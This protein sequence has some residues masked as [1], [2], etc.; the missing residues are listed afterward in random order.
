M[1]ALW[2]L[3]GWSMK[4]YF[5][6]VLLRRELASR[7]A[8]AYARSKGKPL[9][10]IGAGGPRALQG[11]H[12]IPGAV[13]IDI[14]GRRD[15]PHG[16]PGAVTYGDAYDLPFPDG[17]FG[18]VLASHIIEHLED[19]GRA[20]REWLRVVGGDQKALFVITPSWWATY[21]WLHPEHLW[22]WTDHAGGTKGG[23]MYRVRDQGRIL[24]RT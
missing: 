9:L 20:V 24:W 16:T 11:Q 4:S 5:T 23:K 15:I 8:K 12:I 18:A 13:N 2:W 6:D 7:E 17:H 10:N 22:Y 3:L 19:P 1:S 21:G 14:M